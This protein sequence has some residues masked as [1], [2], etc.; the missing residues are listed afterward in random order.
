MLQK[1]SG[2]NKVLVKVRLLGGLKVK[3]E[4]GK[5][6]RE[7]DVPVQKGSSVLKVIKSIGLKEEAFL[8]VLNEKIVNLNEAKINQDSTLIVLPL[9]EG[10]K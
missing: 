5:E 7:L 9:I 6:I 4:L 8:A 10:G 3:N 2:A 1:N